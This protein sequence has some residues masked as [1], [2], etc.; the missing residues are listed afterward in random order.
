MQRTRSAPAEAAT[1]SATGVSGLKATPTPRSSERASAIALYGSSQ[2]STWKVTLSP[3]GR[4]HL[5]EV[6]LRVRDHEMDVED[7]AGLVDER[8]DRAEDDRARS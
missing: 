1:A 3:A 6:V 4:L 2:A 7:A 5:G 8:R